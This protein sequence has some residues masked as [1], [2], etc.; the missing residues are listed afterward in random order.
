MHPLSR[1]D[2]WLLPALHAMEYLVPEIPHPH[3][4][5]TLR[6][7]PSTPVAA[8]PL[9]LPWRL[10]DTHFS[11]PSR[12]PDHGDGLHRIAFSNQPSRQLHKST[13]KNA[14]QLISSPQIKTDMPI[15]IIKRTTI[16]GATQLTPLEMNKIAFEIGHHTN[17]DTQDDTPDNNSTTKT[18]KS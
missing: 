4:V 8:I 7:H 14:T 15:K 10:V 3:M 13:V 11:S 16:D 18:H 12:T 9:L 2:Q 17:V 5:H 1:L 6:H